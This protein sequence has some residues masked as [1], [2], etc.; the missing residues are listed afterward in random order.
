MTNEKLF[1]ADIPNIEF[2]QKTI[3]ILFLVYI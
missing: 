3:E 2:L 1:H